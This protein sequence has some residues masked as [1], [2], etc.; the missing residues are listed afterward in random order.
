[1]STK[2][3]QQGGTVNY[4]KSS[5]GFGVKA[6]LIRFIRSHEISSDITILA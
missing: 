2:Q 3:K 5:E 4:Q 1:M 6:D